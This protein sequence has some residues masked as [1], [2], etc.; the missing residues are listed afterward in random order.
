MLC[1]NLTETILFNNLMIQSLQFVNAMPKLRKLNINE[2]NL[3]N[4]H[5][6]QYLYG[7]PSLK[8]VDLN[9]FYEMSQHIYRYIG[10]FFFFFLYSYL[11][12]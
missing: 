10:F 5:E 3:L 9:N 12:E 4:S 7:R 1:K 6:L 2:C 11:T 8:V